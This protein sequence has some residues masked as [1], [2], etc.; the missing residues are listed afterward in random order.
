MSKRRTGV[1]LVR[2]GKRAKKLSCIAEGYRLA[3]NQDTI[4]VYPNAP[5]NVYRETHFCPIGSIRGVLPKGVK[6]VNDLKLTI[7]EKHVLNHSLCGS[8]RERKVYRNWF[9]ADEGHSDM[10]HIK[11]LMELGLMVK[12][13]SGGQLFGTLYHVTAE[14]AAAVGLSLER[15]SR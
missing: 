7:A 9:D 2:K 5:G 8:S 3:E 14:G 6:V 4:E 13:Q 1:Y 10:P 12:G 11:R 15:L